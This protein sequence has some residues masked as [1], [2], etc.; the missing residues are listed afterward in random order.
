M[1]VINFSAAEKEKIAEKPVKKNYFAKFI[2]GGILLILALGFFYLILLNKVATRGFVLEELKI[3]R[4]Q[5]QKKL[6]KLDI[7]LAIPTSLYSLQSSEIV[8][9][10]V[11]N[12]NE[13]FVKIKKNQ[14]ISRN[15][16]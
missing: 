5:I 8:Q 4:M 3:E 2:F 14:I 10:M 7:A 12:K 1:N 11:E 13:K 6:E 16:N 9:K 15:E